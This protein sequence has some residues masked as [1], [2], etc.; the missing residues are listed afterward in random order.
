MLRT[1]CDQAIEADF[2]NFKAI[3]HNRSDEDTSD[4]D[5]GKTNTQS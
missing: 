2:A 1:E 4:E 5:N 3:I